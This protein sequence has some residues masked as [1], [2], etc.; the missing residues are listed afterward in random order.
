M[1]DQEI[2]DALQEQSDYDP[3]IIFKK[4]S[5]P[6]T[7][8]KRNNNKRKRE[9]DTEDDKQPQNILDLTKQ[10]VNKNGKDKA[11]QQVNERTVTVI[12]LTTASGEKEKAEKKDTKRELRRNPDTE[13]MTNTIMGITK[14]GTELSQRERFATQYQILQN[15]PS[16]KEKM[17]NPIIGIAKKGTELSHREMK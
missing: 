6:T 7:E 1:S 12:K 2:Q 5:T 9:N 10:K 16:V 17:A 11:K 3:D 8:R 15:P 13:K 4:H 14:K